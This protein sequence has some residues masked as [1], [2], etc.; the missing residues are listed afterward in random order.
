MIPFKF[1]KAELYTKEFLSDKV[2]P[3]ETLEELLAE[4]D[5]L[6]KSHHEFRLKIKEVA[7]PYSHTIIVNGKEQTIIDY[8]RW[9]AEDEDSFWAYGCADFNSSSAFN[10]LEWEI[11]LKVAFM[12]LRFKG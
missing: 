9:E 5:E 8:D 10:N 6:C 2:E 7:A 3:E 11:D 1:H 12:N 4:Y